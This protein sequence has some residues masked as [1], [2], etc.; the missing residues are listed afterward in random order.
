MVTQ[1]KMYSV[2]ELSHMRKFT[3]VAVCLTT[4]ALCTSITVIPSVYSYVQKIESDLRVEMKFCEVGDMVDREQLRH[5]ETALLV[6]FQRSYG[7]TASIT[8]QIRP[9][10]TIRQNC[11]D[12]GKPKKF[13][14]D[15]SRF[16]SLSYRGLPVSRHF[17]ASPAS[18][19]PSITP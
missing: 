16:Q 5:H 15:S 13:C 1:K 18:F 8:N 17:P 11:W 2:E 9:A 10:D 7:R 6:D 19:Q 4:V 12:F 3:F 14:T